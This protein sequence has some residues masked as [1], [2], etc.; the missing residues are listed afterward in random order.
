MPDLTTAAQ[1]A[2][3]AVGEEEL[4]TCRVCGCTDAEACAGGCSWVPDPWQHADLCSSCLP[5]DPSDV[6]ATTPAALIVDGATV[7]T[8]ATTYTVSCL[9]DDP[10]DGDLFAITVEFRGGHAWGEPRPLDQQ[11]AV[12]MRSHW[13]LGHDGKWSL[14]P[15]S[16]D[17]GSPP[18][19]STRRP[20]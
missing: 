16:D 2:L 1:A 5:A 8:R 14:K 6:C 7:H 4:A 18:T 17:A 15:S 9:P 3:D 11:W 12:V 19:G 13:N 10:Y 20:H